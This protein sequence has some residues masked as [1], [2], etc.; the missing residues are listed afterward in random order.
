MS[1]FVLSEQCNSRKQLLAARTS[2]GE[3]YATFLQKLFVKLEMPAVLRVGET[4]NDAMSP[5]L[6]KTTKRKITYSMWAEKE[7][8]IKFRTTPHSGHVP[9]H[10]PT[11]VVDAFLPGSAG[12]RKRGDMCEYLDHTVG[13][14]VDHGIEADAE[15]TPVKKAPDRRT[16]CFRCTYWKRVR[17]NESNRVWT[18]SRIEGSKPTKTNRFCMRCQVALCQDCFGPWHKEEGLLPAPTATGENEPAIEEV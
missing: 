15:A 10:I 11:L 13:D 3:T 7:E 14:A 2:K 9:S 12:K 5:Q 16:W 6:P 8:W 17:T 4:A 18:V 1:E